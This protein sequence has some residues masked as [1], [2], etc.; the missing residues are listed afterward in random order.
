MN[1][2]ILL[3][4]I[5]SLMGCDNGQIKS[6]A[7]YAFHDLGDYIEI[8]GGWNVSDTKYESTCIICDKDLGVCSDYT[9]RLFMGHLHLAPILWKIKYWSGEAM[10]SDHFLKRYNG[11]IIATSANKCGMYCN[12]LLYIDRKNKRVYVVKKKSGNPEDVWRELILIDNINELPT[13]WVIVEE[14]Q[15]TFYKRN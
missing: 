1:K 8:M 6:V 9:A 2:I 10:N 7:P 11:L 5:I 3:L 15:D 4:I 13:G 12:S 14:L